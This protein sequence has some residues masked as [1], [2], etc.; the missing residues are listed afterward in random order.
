MKSSEDSR[1]ELRKF[2]LS[3]DEQSPLRGII[4]CLLDDLD[5]ERAKREEAERLRDT[6]LTHNVWL[7]ER[8]VTKGQEAETAEKAL[9]AERTRSAALQAILTELVHIQ[10]HQRVSDFMNQFTEWRRLI[11]RARAAM[12][13]ERL[14]PTGVAINVLVSILRHPRCRSHRDGWR[15][16]VQRFGVAVT[17]PP[18]HLGK[19]GGDQRP[20]GLPP[21]EVVAAAAN[22]SSLTW[23]HGS[24]SREARYTY[25]FGREQ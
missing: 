7:I 10:G 24:F 20:K 8:S 5:A 1:A 6:A 9:A 13:C 16:E 23:D 3:Q 14:S 22:E 12:S 21:D 15:F 11:V 17:A 25:M 4:T 18:G 2:A 19:L